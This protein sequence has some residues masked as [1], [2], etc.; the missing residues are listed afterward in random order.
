MMPTF[1]RSSL[2]F[3]TA[4]FP[5]Y[6][7]KAGFP[8]GAFLSRQQLKPAP[9]MRRPSSSLHPP[10]V[11]LVVNAIIPHCVGPRT[12][13]RTALEGY[14][15]STPGVLARVRVIVSR[16]VITYSTPSVP[17]VGTPRFHRKAAYTRCLRC[18]GAP[19]RPASGS[20]LSLTI[21]SWHA[22]LYDPGEFDHRYG[23][24]LRCRHGLRRV[25]SGSALPKFPQSASRGARISGLPDS[26]TL[27]PARLLA[28]PLTDRT[29]SPR[30]Q[31]AFTSRLPAVWSPSL[32]LDITTTWTGLL[33]L[34]GLAPARMAASLAALEPY[35]RLAR[36]RLP[37]RM[38]D[39]WPRPSVRALAPGTRFP[40]TVSG[41]CGIGS[42]SPWPP[43]FAPPPPLPVA[44]PCSAASLLLRRSLTSHARASSA[45]VSHLPDA[46]QSAL[47]PVARHEISQVPTR[48]FRT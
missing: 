20:G 26:L 43:P 41:T 40:G 18:A 19:R 9:D 29:R 14:Y 5:Q 6:G 47:Q 24:G 34:A 42:R 4:G 33:L 12:R 44:R 30:P 7:W 17:L 37:P 13:L 38:F 2:S 36:I 31:R 15:S 8:S 22:A 16:S 11:H 45:S 21:P 3:R 48:S 10:F 35:V 25:L 32:P 27:R 1:P 39:G 23:P 28:P 46:G